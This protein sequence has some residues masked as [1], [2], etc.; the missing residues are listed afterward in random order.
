MKYEYLEQGNIEVCELVLR[1][2][3]DWFGIEEATLDYIKDSKEMPM[4]V[5]KE[6]GK[7]IGFVSLKKHSSYTTEVYVMGVIPE[8]HRKGIGKKLLI[9][10]ESILAKKGTEFLQVKTL[11]ADRECE[12]YK[13]TRLFYKS[14]GFREVEVFPTLW[15]EDNPCQLL[16]K[17]VKSVNG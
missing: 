7:P 2:V 13:K 11:S 1:S 15:G 9:E 3:P 8:Y 12:F 14:F 5:A 10:A 16:I 6:H 4:V 17:V